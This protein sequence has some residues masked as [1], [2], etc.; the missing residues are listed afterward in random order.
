MS[1]RWFYQLL[2]EEFGPVE[3]RTV[4]ELHRNGTLGAGDLVR[5]DQEQDWLPLNSTSLLVDAAVESDGAVDLEDLSE[6]S[7]EFEE[8]ASAPQ[9]ETPVSQSSDDAAAAIDDLSELSFEFEENA[10]VELNRR[11]AAAEIPTGDEDDDEDDDEHFW[12][13]SLGQT[14]GPMALA[15]LIQV[16][17]AGGVSEDDLVRVGDEGEWQVASSVE[18]VQAAILSSR[19]A[20]ESAPQDKWISP[21]TAARLGN[22]SIVRP[23]KG[24]KEKERGEPVDQE[25][26]S[27]ERHREP[28]KKKKKGKKRGRRKK[29]DDAVLS[30]IFDEVFSEEDKT[31]S[32]AGAMNGD[33]TGDS[34]AASAVQTAVPAPVPATAEASSGIGTPPGSSPAELAGQAADRA[35]Q[36]L[37]STGPTGGSRSN[38]AFEF[39][40]GTVIT[41]L[42]VVLLVGAGA[43]FG[44]GWIRMP[45][46]GTASIPTIKSRVMARYEEYKAYIAEKPT[47]DD[48]QYYTE[49]VVSELSGLLSD[50]LNQ[51]DDG[52]ADEMLP[53]ALGMM[54]AIVS[55]RLDENERR[56]QLETQFEEVMSKVK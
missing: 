32:N 11:A 25:Q 22:A 42:T 35:A 34:N 50:A 49:G 6:L 29:T 19:F 48:W 38:I 15:D 27:T 8:N 9:P 21:A 51:G 26:K 2:S 55:T 40:T 24:S 53:E 46:I 44:M 43:S 45:T 54:L 10:P 23:D 12:Y 28:S 17:E 4:V 7:F 20:E 30:E 1:D 14:M 39:T 33:T 41:I 5:R 37:A 13:Q 18:E 3:S 36:S 16:A 31:T 47:A 56:G 52:Q